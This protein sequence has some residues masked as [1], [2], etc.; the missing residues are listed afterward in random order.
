MMELILRQVGAFFVWNLIYRFKGHGGTLMRKEG[1]TMT[2]WLDQLP[3]WGTY[4]V[5]LVLTGVI[6]QTAFARPLPLLKNLVVYLVLAIGCYLLLIF[7]I[8]GFPI[9][10][11]LLITVGLIIIT[12]IRLAMTRKKQKGDA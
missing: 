1:K 3:N 10:P 7:D 5:I 4:L 6:Y 8:L 9:I 12:R 2:E 11:S